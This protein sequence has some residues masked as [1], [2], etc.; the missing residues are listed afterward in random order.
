[1]Q[2]TAPAAVEAA[3]V[4]E[5]LGEEGGALWEVQQWWSGERLLGAG[6]LFDLIPEDGTGP[7]SF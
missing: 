4:A 3:T 5:R 6:C 2:R 7:P 1:M